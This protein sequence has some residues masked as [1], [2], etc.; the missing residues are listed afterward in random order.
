MKKKQIFRLTTN[1]APMIHSQKKSLE[2]LLLL[3][4][5]CG[6]KIKLFYTCVYANT[7]I[8]GVNTEHDR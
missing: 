3:I 7:K 8:I 2:L 1:N 5:Y 6:G 4:L